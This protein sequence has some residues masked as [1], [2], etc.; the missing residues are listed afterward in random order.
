[1]VSKIPASSAEKHLDANIE[2]KVNSL[3]LS[4]THPTPFVTFIAQRLRPPS[5]ATVEKY[6]QNTTQLEHGGEVTQSP[7][8]DA[9]INYWDHN[10]NTR[11]SIFRNVDM[12]VKPGQVC[13]IL[14]GS[15]SGKSTLLNSIAG[16][17]NG[18][19]VCMTGSIEFNGSNADHYRN[20][21]SIG[22]LQQN[23][24]L[25][26]FLTVRESFI[27]TAYL[28]LPTTMST[29]TKHELVEHYLI[30][31]GLK[32]CANTRIGNPEGKGGTG[33]SAP[34]ISGG[35]RR[36]VSL[37]IQLLTNPAMLLCDEVT[38]GLDAFSSFEVI[39]SLVKLAKS[40][41]K[42]IVISIHQP[43]SEIFKLL[44]DYDSQMV[45]LSKG[46][47]IYSGPI[48]SVLTW[49]ASIGVDACP[50]EVNP[51]DYLLDLSMI[52][53]SSNIAEKSTADRHRSVVQAWALRER[54][55]EHFTSTSAN[56]SPTDNDNELIEQVDDMPFN[57]YLTIEEKSGTNLWTQIQALTSRGW[58][59]QIRDSLVFI[60]IAECVLIGLVLGALYYNLDGSLGGI[61]S[62][63]SLIHAVGAIQSSS[64][65]LHVAFSMVAPSKHRDAVCHYFS[66]TSHFFDVNR[67]KY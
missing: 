67:I 3:S 59:N 62:H 38:S 49:M 27:Y 43:R 52:D 16:R 66:S 56:L 57:T 17:I 28:R 12:S 50:R 8:A 24:Y 5:N 26:P 34:G 47:V 15:G 7:S 63:S 1:M 39:N 45:L 61:R 20:N 19:G 14:G 31:L 53:F 60:C 58:S 42:T 13:I 55:N 35:E 9:T 29:Q 33:G 65:R 44:S 36:R 23:D 22:Y 41:Q 2:L 37:G 51:F 30:E 10:R 18:S 32:E 21:G 40:T 54:G 11:T 6:N 46:D 48:R 4:I 25:M 64:H